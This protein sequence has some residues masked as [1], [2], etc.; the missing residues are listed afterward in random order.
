MEK[1]VTSKFNPNRQSSRWRKGSRSLCANTTTFSKFSKENSQQRSV[2]FDTDSKL[3]GID[4]RCSA[5]ISPDINDFVGR[6]VKSNNTITGFGGTTITKVYKGTIAWSWYDDEGALH[7]F[8]IPHSYYVP[9]AKV[10]YLVRNT[11]QRP[12]H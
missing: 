10:G 11:G 1:Q 3:V 12:R 7:R 5:C 2:K 6:I 4:N 9:D 8:K